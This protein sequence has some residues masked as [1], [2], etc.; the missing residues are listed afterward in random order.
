MQASKYKFSL[1]FAKGPQYTDGFEA[2]GDMALDAD[3][4][5]VWFRVGKSEALKH[6]PKGTKIEDNFGPRKMGTGMGGLAGMNVKTGAIKHVVSVPFQVG[7]VQCNPWVFGQIVFCW[8]TGG[9]AP[10]R[11][12]IVNSDGTG[13]RPVYPESPYEWVTHEAVITP[14]EVAIAI[15]GHRAIPSASAEDREAPTDV[16]GQIP[17]RKQ[18][19]ALA[20]HEE[21]RPD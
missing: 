14:T 13:L 1:I 20:V 6:L 16:R 5:W 19:G 11:T 15:M 10:Q 2:G 7:H 12:W 4:E 8:E 3:E 21:N 18:S 9:K 17:D